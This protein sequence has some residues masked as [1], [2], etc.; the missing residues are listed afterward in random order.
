VLGESRRARVAGESCPCSLRDQY[1]GVVPLSR[2]G[3]L[4]SVCHQPKRR[5]A[6]ARK[7]WTTPRTPARASGSYQDVV[8]AA[9]GSYQDVVPAAEGSYHA[10]VTPRQRHWPSALG[11]A[12]NNGEMV[13][14]PGT[15]TPPPPGNGRRQGEGRSRRGSGRGRART[16]QGG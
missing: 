16:W 2:R 13:A 14:R 4:I 9:A 3:I 15:R 11:P 8:P 6:D 1:L 12:L 10:L 7:A 5:S